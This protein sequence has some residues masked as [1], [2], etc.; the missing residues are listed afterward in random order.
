MAAELKA[1]LLIETRARMHK[2]KNTLATLKEQKRKD[3][4]A[5]SK[6]ERERIAREKAAAEKAER[7]RIAREKAEAERKERERIAAEKA[8]ADEAER[9]R[10]MRVKTA[11][12]KAEKDRIAAEKE[13]EQAKLSMLKRLVGGGATPAPAPPTPYEQVRPMLIFWVL[14]DRLQ[15]VLKGAQSW[16]A[17]PTPPAGGEEA[18]VATMRERLR[19]HDQQVSKEMVQLVSDYEEE[20]LVIA[21]FGE[22]CDVAEI[23]PEVLQ[24]APS[25]DEFL[26]TARAQA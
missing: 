3:D 18:H 19:S 26:T 1:A 7:E 20:L 6:A 24:L 15:E 10:L 2:E 17:A 12:E 9:Q 22:F 14:V 25:A 11:K 13:V 23:L 4:E 5:K 8:A 21:D 16:H